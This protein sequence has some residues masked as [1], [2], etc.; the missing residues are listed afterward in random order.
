MHITNPLAFIISL[1]IIG[2]VCSAI[3]PE[4]SCILYE[5]DSTQCIEY[6]ESSYGGE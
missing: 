2:G 5:Q 6:K 1:I 4:G 3:S